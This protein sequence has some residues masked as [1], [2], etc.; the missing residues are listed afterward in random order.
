M[1]WTSDVLDLG[2]VI[3]GDRVTATEELGGLALTVPSG[4]WRSIV[5]AL[6]DRAGCHYFDWLSA[7]DEAGGPSPYADEPELAGGLRVVCHLVALSPGV[8]RTAVR[9][10]LV[11]T[12]VPRADPVL[13][14][15]VGAYAG[16]AWHERETHEMFGIDFRD[17]VALETLLLPDAFEGHPL[18]K[19]FVLASRVVKPWPGAKEPGESDHDVSAAESSPGRR[20]TRPPGVPDPEQ[21]GPRPPGTPTPDP[22]A[23][24][25]A[26]PAAGA[27]RPRR[28]R[29]ATPPP[30][31]EDGGTDG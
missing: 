3:G 9:D 17:G 4:W 6:R 27:S 15:L 11:Q 8:G 23:H 21:W 18:R 7:V 2:R 16:A 26:G 29:R 20:R 24:A 30:A 10:V 1:T 25:T 22:L 31:A 13:D 5:L 28:S 19:E 14:S 12:T